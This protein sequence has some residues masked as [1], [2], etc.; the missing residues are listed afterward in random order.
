MAFTLRVESSKAW[1]TVPKT[2][3]SADGEE[4]DVLDAEGVEVHL[5][6][7]S[8]KRVRE[9]WAES[10][11]R[12]SRVEV[13][14]EEVLE[15]LTPAN[16]GKDREVVARRKVPH[17]IAEDDD[18][19][20]GAAMMLFCD[21]VLAWKGVAGEDGNG[22][23]STDEYKNALTE[24]APGLIRWVSD[25]VMDTAHFAEEKVAKEAISDA[26]FRQGS[27]GALPSVSEVA[28]GVPS[29]R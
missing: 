6:Q 26:Q 1:F 2:A 4:Y 23:P 9:I 12:V 5:R 27:N 18:V 24:Q 8:S 16:R 28:D 14:T 15:D 3:T 7:L 11:E 20:I 29:V 13:V 17:T 25:V 21:S 22:L 19:A 10:R